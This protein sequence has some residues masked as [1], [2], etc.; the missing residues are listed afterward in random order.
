MYKAARLDFE[1]GQHPCSCTQSR[2]SHQL[3]ISHSEPAI[4][5][6]YFLNPFS[7]TVRRAQ[8][9]KVLTMQHASPL[10]I[11]SPASGTPGAEA[12][13]W[14]AAICLSPAMRAMRWV[15]NPNSVGFVDFCYG[16][17]FKRGSKMFQSPCLTA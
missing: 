16:C 15:A 2:N 12:R 5:S 11:A 13:S 6:P 8:C 9:V 7:R 3:R 17:K 10:P 14:L 4:K 1:S